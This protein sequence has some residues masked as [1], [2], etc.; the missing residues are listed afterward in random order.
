MVSPSVCVRRRE[1]GESWRC[2]G[3]GDSVRRSGSG[4]GERTRR[5]GDGGEAGWGMGGGERDDS[6]LFLLR[7]VFLSVE[8]CF[9]ARSDRESGAPFFVS[10]E[11]ETRRFNVSGLLVVFKI[12]FPCNLVMSK[13]TTTTET[14]SVLPFFSANEVSAFAGSPPAFKASIAA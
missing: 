4:S 10:L 2:K 13:T 9:G 7:V 6:K 8:D 11:N 3:V 5:L 12:G 1:D 14:L